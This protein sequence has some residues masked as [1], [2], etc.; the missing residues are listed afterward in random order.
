MTSCCM[1]MTPCREKKHVVVERK[2]PERG[3][4]G[5]KYRQEE[6]S[7]TEMRGRIW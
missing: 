2:M 6:A 4:G 1:G 3:H 7:Q 5:C